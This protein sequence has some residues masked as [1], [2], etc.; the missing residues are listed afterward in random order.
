MVSCR[1]SNEGFEAVGLYWFRL[2]TYY[3]VVLVVVLLEGVLQLVCLCLK[4]ECPRLFIAQ[5]SDFTVGTCILLEGARPVA[6][7]WCNP[8]DVVC[9]VVGYRTP[10]KVYRFFHP[11]YESL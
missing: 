1:D 11:A 5:G 2:A 6:L 8:L 3:S 10:R 9:R 7:G 4:K